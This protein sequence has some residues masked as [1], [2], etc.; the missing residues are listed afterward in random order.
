MTFETKQI[1][2]S[3]NKSVDEVYEFTSNP[4]NLPKW[5]PSFFISIK[6][7]GEYWIADSPLGEAKV[8]FAEKNNFGILDH[9]I[10]LPTGVKVYNPLRVIKNN[11]GSEIVLTLFKLPGVSDEEYTKDAKSVEGDLK[12]LKELIERKV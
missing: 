9:Y 5:V 6:K 8:K 10:D 7:D 1:S 2:I 12:K 11:E 4:E 3:I